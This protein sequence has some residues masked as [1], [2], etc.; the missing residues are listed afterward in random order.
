MQLSERWET[1]VEEQNM[2]TRHPWLLGA[3]GVGGSIGAATKN[4][5]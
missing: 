3:Y 4:N 5:F 1:L 2:N